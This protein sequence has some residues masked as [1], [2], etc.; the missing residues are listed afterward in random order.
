[1]YLHG[2]DAAGEPTRF[3][4]VNDATCALLGYTREEL[5]GLTPRAIDAAPA[6][7]QLRRMM[8]ELVARR[9]GALRE[10]PPP[11]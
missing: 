11:A 8:A 7:G 3:L 2:L 4:A 1:M 10:R 9:V 6:P 5:R